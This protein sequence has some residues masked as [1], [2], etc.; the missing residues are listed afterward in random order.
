MA[1]IA[2]RSGTAAR[3]VYAE[4][5][6]VG[7]GPTR[8][9]RE[10]SGFPPMIADE[11]AARRG[12]ARSRS[13]PWATEGRDLARVLALSDGIFAFAMTLLVLGLALPAGFTQSHVAGVLSNLKSAFLA[14][15]LSFF[16]IYLYWVAHHQIFQYIV[17][18][19]R[20]LLDLNVV[21][22]L[23]IA[24][25]PFVTNL[26]SAA[27]GEFLAFLVYAVVQVAAGTSLFV[28]WVYATRVQ[29]HVDP[30]MP[31]EWIRYISLRTGL[32]PAYFA[33]SIAVALWNTTYAEYSWLGVFLLQL[34]LRY[35]IGGHRRGTRSDP[36]PPPAKSPGFR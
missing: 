17:S 36:G 6:E 29:R 8:E 2:H 11:E 32:S 14:Y 16:V 30:S 18:Y 22:L 26:L 33:G 3:A 9:S 10:T 21:F 28:V 25:M 4:E 24:V 34:A 31:T 12:H 27:S 1:E 5:T 15:L 20:R 7:K 35:R 13:P 23:F 19:D